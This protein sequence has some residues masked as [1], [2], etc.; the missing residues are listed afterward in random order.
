MNDMQDGSIDGKGH[1]YEGL[2]KLGLNSENSYDGIVVTKTFEEQFP[3]LNRINEGRQHG[4]VWIT[5]ISALM[6]HCLDKQKVREAI[7]HL[8][9]KLELDEGCKYTSYKESFMKE[10]GL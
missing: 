6:E 8:I 1:T 3:S 9:V 7:E 4:D 10:L 5:P 2:E